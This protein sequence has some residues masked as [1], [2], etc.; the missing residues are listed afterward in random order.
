M[1][2]AWAGACRPGAYRA[3]D[4]ATTA[5]IELAGDFAP[6]LLA[7]TV[8]ADGQVRAVDVMLND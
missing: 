6:L 7:V 1:A 3:G 5:T 8:G 2:A 4:G